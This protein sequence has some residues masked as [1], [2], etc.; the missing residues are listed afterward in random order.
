MPATAP[1]HEQIPAVELF[2]AMQQEPRPQ[3]IDVRRPAEYEQ[4]HVAGARHVE[5]GPELARTPA[6]AGLDRRRRTLV[7]C[8]TG[9]RSSAA[10]AQLAAAGFTAL[11]NVGDGMAGWSS[12]HLPIATGKATGG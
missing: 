8:R 4:G 6:L 1:R 9:Y 12:N 2:A 3:V 7:I 10:I 5:L 11:G